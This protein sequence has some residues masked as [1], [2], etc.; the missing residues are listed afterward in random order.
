[1]SPD[2][3]AMS[4]L[5]AV[6]TGLPDA[7]HLARLAEAERVPRVVAWAVAWQESRTNLDPRLRPAGCRND[8]EVGRMQVKPSTAKRVC[9]TLNIWAYTGNVRCGLLYLRLLHRQTGSWE[10]AIRA[11]Q[12]PTCQ[13]PTPYEQA[14][15]AHV[16]RLSLRLAI[17]TG[18]GP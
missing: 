13:G 15:L 4:V 8:C 3:L 14:V 12:C 9:P 1:V 7:Y 11:Y 16:G 2:T 18:Q 5:L 17:L 6:L 10:L